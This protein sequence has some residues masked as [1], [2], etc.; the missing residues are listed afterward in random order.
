MDLE[1]SLRK[2]ANVNI[3]NVGGAGLHLTKDL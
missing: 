3:S 2:V 1:T